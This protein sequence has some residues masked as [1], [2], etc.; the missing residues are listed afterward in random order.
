M[1]SFWGWVLSSRKS[2]GTPRA[3]T[4]DQALEWIGRYFGRARENDFVM[5]RSAPG[6]GHENWRADLD[7]LLSPKGMKQVIEKTEVAA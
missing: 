1:R 3:E 6:Q 2:D 5:R 7:Y 4:A